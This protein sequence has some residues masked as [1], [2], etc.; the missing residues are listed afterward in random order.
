MLKDFL[1]D[2]CANKI[3]SMQKRILLAVLAVTVAAG[4]NAQIKKGALLLGGQLSFNSQK[5]ESTAPNA[6]ST[7]NNAVFISPA[8]GRAI[9]ENLIAGFDL[10][11]SH[12]KYQASPNAKQLSDGY[13]AGFFIRRYKELGKGFYLFGQ[14]RVGGMYNQQ[15]YT[16]LAQPSANASSRGFTAQLGFYPGVSYAVSKKLQVEAGFSNLAAL[17]YEHTRQ[18]PAGNNPVYTSNAFSFSSS[19]SS[20]AG[21]SIGFQVLLN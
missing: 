11:Y 13:G 2:V 5:N 3:S 8:F 18:T 14:A 7:T 20:F 16:D 15:R 1:F 10:L 19:L 4:G 21:P 12:G 6:Y 9:R 17:R